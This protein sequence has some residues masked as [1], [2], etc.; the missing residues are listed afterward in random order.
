MDIWRRAAR[1]FTI[2]KVRHKSK[3]EKMRVTQ[4]W[5]NWGKKS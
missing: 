3:G 4:I 2:P 5:K 1:T